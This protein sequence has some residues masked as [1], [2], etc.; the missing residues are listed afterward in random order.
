MAL[1]ASDNFN[2]S[3]DAHIDTGNWTGV[4]GDISIESNHITSYPAGAWAGSYWSADSFSADQQA[5]LTI[6]ARNLA[7]NWL[8]PGVRM[9]GTDA[10]TAAGYAV[11]WNGSSA[12]IAKRS[13]GTTTSLKTITAPSINDVVKVRVS[14]T[15]NTL[16][17]ALYNGV[18]IDSYT[19]SSS[20]ITSG[21]AG[22][23]ATGS[24]DAGSYGD[25]FGADNYTAASSAAPRAMMRARRMRV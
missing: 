11:Q 6:L 3:N 8:G 18:L 7:S 1:P 23:W 15:T 12:R 21:N 16:I 17:E 4:V 25:D 20:P 9:S 5:W 2:R 14:G 19:D 13:G 10:S 22:I 24:N